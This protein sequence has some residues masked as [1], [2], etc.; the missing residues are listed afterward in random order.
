MHLFVSAMLLATTAL[1]LGIINAQPTP[2]ARVTNRKHP[3]DRAH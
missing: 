1:L 2:Y 3:D